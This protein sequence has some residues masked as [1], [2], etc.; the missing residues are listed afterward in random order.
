MNGIISMNTWCFRGETGTIINEE[1]AA[2]KV[3]ELSIEQF[4]ALI[5]EVIEEK[6]RELLEDTD[7]GLE[8]KDEVR[9]RL[10]KSLAAEQCG[11]KSIP[12]DVV[13]SRAGLE[14]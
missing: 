5:Q 8:L 10:K 1:V 2:M 9:E 11:E 13:A 4:K 7:L 6:F 14:W 3:K 12:I